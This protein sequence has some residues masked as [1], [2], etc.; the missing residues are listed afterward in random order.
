MLPL[1]EG[2]WKVKVVH[3]TPFAD[4]KVCQESAAYATLVM[5]IGKERAQGHGHHHHH[6]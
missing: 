1:I 4:A 5:P 3:K 6:H 2:L